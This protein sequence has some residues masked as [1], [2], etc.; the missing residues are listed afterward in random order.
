MPEMGGIELAEEL[1][2]ERPSL[3]VIYVSGYSDNAIQRGPLVECVEKPF[4][5]E[6]IL[7]ALRSVLACSSMRSGAGAD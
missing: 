2:R 7:N 4:Q 1:L 6:T 3:P 5:P